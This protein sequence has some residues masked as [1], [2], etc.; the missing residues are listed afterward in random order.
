MNFGENLYN[1]LQVN[2]QPLVLIA[3]LVTG[4]VPLFKKEYSKLIPFAIVAVIAV[5]LTFNTAGSKDFLLQLFN[6][7]IG[8]GAQ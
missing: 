5:G 1:W 4:V 3:L 8:G 6:K 2:M 7:I